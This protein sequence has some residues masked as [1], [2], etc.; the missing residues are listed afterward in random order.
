MMHE[1]LF[2]NR[3]ELIERCRTKV[4]QRPTRAIPVEQMQNDVPLFLDQLIDTLKIEQT[5][6]PL[7]RREA[8]GPSESE[9]LA[10]KVAMSAARHGRELFLLG[11]SIDQVV[12]NYGDL[13]QAITDLAYK[14][15][16]PFQI[17]E[18]RTLS[19]CLDNAIASAVVEFAT[20]HD[21]ISVHEMTEKIEYL[22]HDLRS[23]LG[24]ALLAFAAAKARQSRP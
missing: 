19:R 1:F 6:D 22:T 17:D 24:T 7:T 15:D 18:F 11:F 8:L 21:S 9:S 2:D 3:A 14:L 5:L 23:T 13:C 12:H 4:A 20:Q 10:R 16:A